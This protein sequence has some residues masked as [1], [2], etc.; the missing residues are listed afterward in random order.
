MWPYVLLV[1]VPIIIQETRH[2][3]IT[4]DSSEI[5]RRSKLPMIIFWSF[6]TLLLMLRSEKVGIDLSKY[7]LIFKSMGVKSWGSAITRSAEFANNFMLKTIYEL[8]ADFRWVIVISAILSVAFISWAYVK[9]TSDASL[10]IVLYINM[11]NFI[12]LFSGLRQSI[13]ISLGF[14]AF[15]FVRR[16]K[17]IPFIL[18]V[19]LAML[20]HTSAFMLAF[21]YPLYHVRITRKWL[22]GIIPVLLLLFLFNRP[23]FTFLG[24]ILEQFTKYDSSI[25]LTGSYTMLILLILFA[26]FSFIIPDE[27]LLDDDTIG[28]RNFLLLTVML[29]MFAPLHTIAMR[30]NY[31]YLAFIPLVIPRIIECRSV[32]WNQIAIIAR[33]VFI[34]YF[35]F[36]FFFTVYQKNDLMTFP[37]RFFWGAA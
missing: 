6:L 26:A 9:Y 37:Y 20:F 17:L 15:E 23:I 24:S 35:C 16:K 14:L 13:A 8:T 32:R 34:I 4:F 29:Q 2:L 33:Y 36:Y 27:S 7:I 21:M 28:M 25:T 10:S 5:K 11:T 22:V 31:Y 1:F 30:M 12:L 18:V 3:K 19:A